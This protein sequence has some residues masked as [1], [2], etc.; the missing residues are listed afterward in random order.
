MMFLTFD[1]D[2]LAECVNCAD[3]GWH[4]HAGKVTLHSP[5]MDAHKGEY[6]Y[7]RQLVQTYFHMLT[8]GCRR[9][10]RDKEGRMDATTKCSN[11]YCRSNN[12]ASP[13][14][15]ATDAAI[16]SMYLATQCPIPICTASIHHLEQVDKADDEEDEH[17]E[18]N[19]DEESPNTA[20]DLTAATSPPRSTPR[21][22]LSSAVELD[23]LHRESDSNERDR[24]RDLSG[25]KRRLDGRK[26]SLPKQKLLD[27]IKKSFPNAHRKLE[28]DLQRSAGW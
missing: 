1:L 12:G 18:T 15:S 3:L 28:L 11:A 22:R 5:A 24:E 20:N 25:G 2:L 13:S 16:L 26:F 21:R 6:A 27:A 14:I 4:L 7:A 10:P 23:L 8:I 17:P 9:S 19:D